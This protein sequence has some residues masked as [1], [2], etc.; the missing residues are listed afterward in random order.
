MAIKGM[1]V[2]LI[3]KVKTGIDPFDA[4]IYEDKEI[5]VENVLVSPTSSD[6]VI[7]QVQ[8]YGKKSTYTLGIPKGDEHDWENKEVHFFGKKY[9]TFGP[10]IEGIESMVPTQWHKKVMVER[11][12]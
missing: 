9:R 2:V 10:V 1:T 7:N 6:D 3:D 12:E 4:P 5:P 11:Y 8:L